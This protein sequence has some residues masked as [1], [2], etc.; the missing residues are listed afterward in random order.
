MVGD[1]W[2]MPSKT[3]R[4]QMEFG[5]KKFVIWI[6]W[7]CLINID[8]IKEKCHKVHVYIYI[9]YFNFFVRLSFTNSFLQNHFSYTKVSIMMIILKEIYSLYKRHASHFFQ[10][11]NCDIATTL[12][13]LL[14]WQLFHLGNRNCQRIN[15]EK[16]SGWI[17]SKNPTRLIYGS[18]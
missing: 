9:F 12:D 13:P 5:M 2:L 18:L 7:Q 4:N 1:I 8:E 11:D 10:L 3:K 16:P 6:F 17:L 15:I 14:D